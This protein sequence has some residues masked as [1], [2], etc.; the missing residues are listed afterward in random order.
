[1]YRW[2]LLHFY[3]QLQKFQHVEN[4]LRIM[5][6]TLV[7]F[8][9]VGTSS[10]AIFFLLSYLQ[11][12]QGVRPIFAGIISYALTFGGTYL[13]HHHWTFESSA[14]HKESLPRYLM[15]QLMCAGV[16]SAVTEILTMRFSLAPFLSS[17]FVTVLAS[18]ASFAVSKFWVF[19]K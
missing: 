17:L 4:G 15:L 18:S 8:V 13:I 9:I 19:S 2:R 6:V 1:M 14:T 16:A 5:S 12:S 10:A 3:Q 7:R 11:I